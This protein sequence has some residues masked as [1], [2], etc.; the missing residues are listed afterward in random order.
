MIQIAY[1]SSGNPIQIVEREK[2]NWKVTI[3]YYNGGGDPVMI[4]EGE[5]WDYHDAYNLAMQ[6]I[7]LH[8]IPGRHDR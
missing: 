8:G 3:V 5:G 6:D 2:T 7:S 1:D 4:G